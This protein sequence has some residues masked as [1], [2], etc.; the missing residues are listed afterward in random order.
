[1]QN[2][3]GGVGGGF[4]SWLSITISERAGVDVAGLVHL[5]EAAAVGSAALGGGVGAG[6]VD[7]HQAPATG[8]QG[9][10]APLEPR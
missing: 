5:A 7:C 8:H 6:A 2:W 9:Q 10:P 4:S 1:M 3:W